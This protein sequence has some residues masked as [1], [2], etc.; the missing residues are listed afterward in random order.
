M[1]SPFSKA[2]IDKAVA[3]V[4]A[5]NGNTLAVGVESEAGERPAI[6]IEAQGE[7]ERVTWAAWA[8]TK[9]TKAS[10]AVG[11]KIGIRWP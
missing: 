9:L 7:T 11:A 1:S 5:Q 3:D 2:S 8:K 4:D 10:T 6:V